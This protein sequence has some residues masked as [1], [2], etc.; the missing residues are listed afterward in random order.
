MAVGCEKNIETAPEGDEA[1]GVCSLTISLPTDTK[2]TFDGADGYKSSWDEGDKILV[3]TGANKYNVYTLSAGA[4]EKKATFTGSGAPRNG[5]KVLYPAKDGDAGWGFDTGEVKYHFPQSYVWDVQASTDNKLHSVV[6]MV[7]SIKGTNANFDYASGAILIEYTK[8]TKSTAC[9]TV[10]LGGMNPTG[11]TTL[12]ND[13]TELVGSSGEG[14]ITIWMN[15]DH[16]MIGGTPEHA[17]FLLPIPVGTYNSLT[18]ELIRWDDVPVVGSKF[19]MASTKSFSIENKQLR[20][21]PA[22]KPDFPEHICYMPDPGTE[23]EDGEYILVYDRRDDTGITAPDEYGN[24]WIN[25]D[26]SLREVFPATLVTLDN[27]LGFKESDPYY[28]KTGVIID[29]ADYETGVWIM[30]Y[31]SRTGKWTVTLS[32]KDPLTLRSVEWET[33]GYGWNQS[34]TGYVTVTD[35]D[36][37]IVRYLDVNTFRS[38]NYNPGTPKTDPIFDNGV[39][40]RGRNQTTNIK[41]FVIYN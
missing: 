16:D 20:K 7:G 17:K 24:A 37:Q 12:N 23:F 5:G 25:G 21:L 1:Q 31:N 38:G 13:G 35:N 28:G 9:L 4:G 3:E 41:M 8:I 39:F 30:K 14:T 36:Y 6:P 22:I 34:Y 29:Q 11:Y 27:H 40:W 18:T 15:K 33:T 32:G 19:S 26:D 10:D 2:I